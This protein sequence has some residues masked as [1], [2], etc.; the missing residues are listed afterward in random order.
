MFEKAHTVPTTIPAPGPLW[1]RVTC[2]GDCV[3]VKEASTEAGLDTAA[4]C[5]SS[6]NFNMAGGT[7]GFMVDMGEPA[8]LVDDLT[9]KSWD[10]SG[11]AIAARDTFDISW[12]AN[13]WY[14]TFDQPTHD[15]AGNLTYDG[16]YA[17]SYDAWRCASWR[18]RTRLLPRTRRA[19]DATAARATVWQRCKGRG[20]TI[21]P[22]T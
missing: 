18:A 7:I 13:T 20:A 8:C 4:D 1:V 22:T 10:G 19:C 11:W 17:Y 15:A 12:D 21:R 3:T 2:D 5:Y 16:L 14:Y 9:V 6:T